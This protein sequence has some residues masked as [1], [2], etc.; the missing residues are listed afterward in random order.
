MSKYQKDTYELTCSVCD[1]LFE[2]NSPVSKYCSD[3]CRQNKTSSTDFS[4]CHDCGRSL[5]DVNEGRR[6][7]FKYCPDRDC[8]KNDED[9]VTPLSE[10]TY[11]CDH[12]ESSFTP[13]SYNQRFCGSDECDESRSIQRLK[14]SAPDDVSHLDATVTCL[15]C[16]ETF[17]GC[18]PNASGKGRG[19]F[20]KEHDMTFY[21]YKAK[22]PEVNRLSPL[23]RAKSGHKQRG[24]E[25]SE[26]SRRR[27]SKSQKE[28]F[29]QEDVWNKGETKESHPS[30][31]AIAEKNKEALLGNT[32]HVQ[33]TD[34]QLRQLSR[35]S[36]ENWQKPS[37]R[38]R[39]LASRRRAFKNG[40][41]VSELHARFMQALVNVDMWDTF[42]FDYEV[43]WTDDDGDPH[44]IDIVSKSQQ[45][46]IEVDGCLFHRCPKHGNYDSLNDKWQLRID[47]NVESDR[48]MERAFETKE[49]WT[50]L[51]FWEHDIE[52]S[53]TDCLEELAQSLNT[54]VDFDGAFDFDDI[55]IE[56]DWISDLLSDSNDCQEASGISFFNCRKM[57]FPFYSYTDEEI[58]SDL[59]S[60]RDFDVSKIKGDDRCIS[61]H[62]SRRHGDK[63]SKEYMPHIWGTNVKGNRSAMQAWQDD[64]FLKKLI[65]NRKKYADCVTSS[66]LRTGLKLLCSVPKIFPSVLAKYLV[67]TYGGQ[68]PTVLD[69]S[70]G[71]GSRM[72]GCHASSGNT[73]YVGVEPWEETCH[74]LDT[75]RRTLELP[76][77]SIICSPFEDVSRPSKAPFDLVMTSPPHFDK[78]HYTDQSDQSDVR[79]STYE[80][81]KEGFLRPMVEQSYEWSRNNA[82]MALHVTDTENHNLVSD[83]R[84][85]MNDVGYTLKAPVKWSRHHVFTNSDR[86]EL[87]LIG[88][89]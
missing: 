29:K 64:S 66:T 38:K 70:A 54:A 57:G 20:Q 5:E 77:T 76:S 44:P 51:R 48:A 3:S 9:D 18:I 47:S 89:K 41:H 84:S 7:K 35:K 39:N 55:D 81:W 79:Y 27:M 65:K 52:N 30:V 36:K 16:D 59:R 22:Y 49:G 40:E 6:S 12:C 74:Q 15:E 69:P 8:S 50:L 1:S 4:K 75:I 24:Q 85:I 14:E 42:N 78:E 17:V 86:C 58:K 25:V 82:H 34:E 87:I 33:H 2:A 83:T 28:R 56:T 32:N 62:P 73:T 71:W 26:E 63:A 19:H 60:L 72:V 45:L 43:Y 80:P 11:T 46:A 23:S 61:I 37:Y 67:S 31:A 21:E 88:Q 13:S 10:R 68:D 53:L